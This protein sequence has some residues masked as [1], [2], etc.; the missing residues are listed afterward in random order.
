MTRLVF[1]A[2]TM[3]C[4]QPGIAQDFSAL[5]AASGQALFERTWVPAPASTAAADGLGPYYNARS[6]AACHPEGGGSGEAFALNLVV[7]EPRYGVLLQTQAV[8]G[9]AAEASANITYEPSD[10]IALP[11]G[12]SVSLYKPVIALGGLQQ[13]ALSG[14]VGLRR[15]PALAGLAQL[16]QVPSA[17]LATQAD[18]KDSDGDGISGQV[19]EAQGRFGWKAATAT[20]RLQTARALSL[21]L[22][23]GNSVFPAPA[24]DCTPVQTAC[25]QAARAQTGAA[26][27]A[28]DVVLDL[29]LAYLQA[30]P[31]PRSAPPQG[32]E[33][34]LFTELG[35]AACH[36]PQLAAGSTQLY[37]FSD[38]LIHDMGSGLADTADSPPALASEWRTPPLWGLGQVSRFLHD[39][40]AATLEEAI[41]WHGGEAE[42]SV[43]AYRNLNGRE[44]KRLHHWLLGL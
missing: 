40:R 1:L 33:T 43:R 10:R 36:V 12:A 3:A 29:L 8:T 21:D 14:G 32:P 11:E 20:L 44:R 38:L 2:A 22:G 23:L 13:G 26:L 9:L 19:P 41:L 4:I 27:E 42:A 34:A 37:P 6:C 15:A 16:E 39:G 18:P 24:G 17:V 25:L 35:C 28:P 7:N 5:D 31:P 30:L